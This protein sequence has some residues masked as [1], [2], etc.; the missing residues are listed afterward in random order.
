MRHSIDYNLGKYRL[1]INYWFIIIFLVI[2]TGL[3]ELG[4]WQLS[5]AQEKQQR[6]TKLA[7]FQDLVINDL[8]LVDQKVINNFARLKLK[9]QLAEF[10]N[11]LIEN[12]IQNGELGYHVLNLV[13]DIETGRNFLVNRGWIEGTANRSDIPSVELPELDWE[14]EGRIYPINQQVL[15]QD[16]VLENYN[17]VIRLPVLD[18]HVLTLL[19]A[20]FGLTLEPYLLRLNGKNKDV[21]DVNWV[22]ISMTPEKHLGYAFQ[23]FGLSLTFLIVSLFALIKKK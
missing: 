13:K 1:S 19:E 11:I 10:K 16:A 21:F 20:Q 14:L 18:T 22:W 17:R 3:N 9:V 4:F 15:S 8:N 2:Q 7:N 23:W 5:R 6:L 12:K